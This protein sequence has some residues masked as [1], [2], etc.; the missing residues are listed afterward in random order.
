MSIPN[1]IAAHFRKEMFRRSRRASSRLMSTLPRP[2]TFHIGASWAGKAEEQTRLKKVPF[3]ADGLLGTWRD[4]TLARPKAVKSQDA[5]EDFFY[6]QEVRGLSTT[7]LHGVL[8][9]IPMR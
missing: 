8:N 9:I 7:I 1:Q 4:Q 6:I 3:P 2:Y 5:G